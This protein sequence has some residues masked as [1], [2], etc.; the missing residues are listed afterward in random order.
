MRLISSLSLASS[1]R[2]AVAEGRLSRPGSDCLYQTQWGTHCTIGAALLPSELDWIAAN[3][4][5]GQTL[6]PFDRSMD[7]DQSLR[8]PV[9]THPDV[10]FTFEDVTL[11]TSLQTLFDDAQQKAPDWGDDEE[12]TERVIEDFLTSA[13]P[14]FQ[15][16]GVSL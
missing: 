14:I 7:N 16:H 12:T 1:L 3:G 15:R 5:N 4:L 2:S 6:L 9:L 8:P 10:P 13:A 11:A